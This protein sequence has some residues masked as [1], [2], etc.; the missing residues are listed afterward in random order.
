MVKTRLDLLLVERKLVESRN[1]A[2]RLVMA[3]Q[4]RVGGQVVYKP[5]TQVEPSAGIEIV[6]GPR[7]VSRGGEKLDA[8]MVQFGLDVNG[9]TCAD[10]G[11]STGGFVDCLLQRGAKKVYAVDVGKGLL[12][13][14]LR[15][16]V[17]V[18]VM[19]STNAR[20]VTSL[21]ETIQFLSMDASFISLK[22]LLPVVR[23]WL[24]PDGEMV[25]L[26]KPQFEAGRKEAA[27]GDGVIRD[28]QIHRQV[29]ENILTY[30]QSIGLRAGGLIRSPLHGPKGNIEFLAWLRQI[31]EAGEVKKLVEGAMIELPEEVTPPA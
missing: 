10:V 23:N 9:K 27:R 6:T 7:F 5:A 24:A 25:V 14:K 29:L 2:Q 15:Q 3:G 16:R 11:S 22:T 4:V 28:S 19:E 31:G 12:H 20:L 21:P 13:W 18:V 26:I 1:L 8:A 17:E 30:A